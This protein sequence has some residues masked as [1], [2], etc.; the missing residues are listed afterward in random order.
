MNSPENRGIAPE[1]NA[2]KATGRKKLP[3]AVVIIL[4]VIALAFVGAAVYYGPEII[5]KGIAQPVSEKE[6][7]LAG[8]QFTLTDEFE[9][10]TENEHIALSEF[11]TLTVYNEKFSLLEG[12]EDMTLRQ[13]L[14]LVRD[15]NVN[16]ASVIFKAD[17]GIEYYTFKTESNGYKFYYFVFVVKGKDCFYTAQ[18]CCNA[19]DANDKMVRRFI[20]WAATAKEAE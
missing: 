15:V 9:I 6:F 17:N 5:R 7:T 3:T 4:L 13:Y 19:S 1:K 20:D 8:L 2:K 14:E 10:Y 11:A 16:E 18:F 12:L